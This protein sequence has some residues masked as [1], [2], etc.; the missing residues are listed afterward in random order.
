[1]MYV[2]E[3]VTVLLFAYLLVASDSS[4]VVLG[5]APARQTR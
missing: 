1:M 3:I 5:G 2:T 4:R